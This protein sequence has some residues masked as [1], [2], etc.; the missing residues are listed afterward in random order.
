M[1]R[2]LGR[3]EMDGLPGITTVAA[4][5]DDFV[6]AMFDLR[7]DEELIPERLEQKG[8]TRQALL[9]RRCMEELRRM[10]GV[11]LAAPDE[12][13]LRAAQ[14]GIADLYDNAYQWRPSDG[15]IGERR[16]GKSM[17][18]YIKS[19][20]TEWDIERLYGERATI[21]SGTIP[22]DY[23]ESTELEQ[24]PAPAEGDGE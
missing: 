12:D 11:R 20:I 16:A 21:E 4:F 23:T 6:A 7:R 1:A 5:T 22:T 8:L 15:A 17:R 19:W 2:W 24:A 9:A 10:R 13:A 3:D 18:Q 14:R